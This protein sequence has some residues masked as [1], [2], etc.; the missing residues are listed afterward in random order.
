MLLAGADAFFHGTPREFWWSFAAVGR[1]PSVSG[2]A[3]QNTRLSGQSGA[4]GNCG[5]LGS[6]WEASAPCPQVSAIAARATMPDM[7]ERPISPF[8]MA[9]SPPWSPE[10]P[11]LSRDHHQR[12]YVYA[13]E[14]VG[15]VLIVH[16]D[17]AIRRELTN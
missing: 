9:I 8:S 17:A 10:E 11:G 4:S 16:P 5:L 14:Q 6:T 13:L 7:V 3:G 15:D 2:T 12:A 1:A